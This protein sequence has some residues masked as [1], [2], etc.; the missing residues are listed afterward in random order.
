MTRLT[1]TAKGQI[2]LKQ[3][4]L[5][6]LNVGPGQQVEADKLPNGG[7]VVRASSPTGTIDDFIGSLAGKNT[8]RLTLR[9]IQEIAETGWSGEK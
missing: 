3:D 6:H 4:L 5:R 1:I 9:E 2:T 7:I 8:P